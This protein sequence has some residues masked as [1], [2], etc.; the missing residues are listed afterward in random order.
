MWQIYSEQKCHTV[1]AKPAKY[2]YIG[3]SPGCIY[4]YKLSGS[5]KVVLYQ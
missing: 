5:L 4:V 1:L 3:L 2:S